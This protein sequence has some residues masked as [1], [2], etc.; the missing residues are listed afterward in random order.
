MTQ[1]SSFHIFHIKKDLTDVNF[2]EAYACQDRNLVFSCKQNPPTGIKTVTCSFSLWWP[3]IVS[4]ASNVTGC[5]TIYTHVLSFRL[6]S[7]SVPVVNC[8]VAH[9]TLQI[10]NHLNVLIIIKMQKTDL[11]FWWK[12]QSSQSCLREVVVSL[13]LILLFLLYAEHYVHV[14]VCTLNTI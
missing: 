10:N 4:S 14:K 6:V 2:T 3:Q 8:V 11:C 5:N 13:F 12:C 1:H 7:C 9:L